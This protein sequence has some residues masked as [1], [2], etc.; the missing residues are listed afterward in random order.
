MKSRPQN[1][2]GPEAPCQPVLACAILGEVEEGDE[3][4]FGHMW[5]CSLDMGSPSA[6]IVSRNQRQETGPTA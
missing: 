4:S 6:S 1:P 2:K 3:D 5:Y